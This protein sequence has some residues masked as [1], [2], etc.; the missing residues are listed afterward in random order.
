MMKY[1]ILLC[2]F[3]MHIS[4]V[5]D[6]GENPVLETINWRQLSKDQREFKK[7]Q[8]DVSDIDPLEQELKTLEYP[9]FLERLS[10]KTFSTNA[11]KYAVLYKH[12]RF[13]ALALNAGANAR[14]DLKKIAAYPLLTVAVRNNDKESVRLLLEYGALVNDPAFTTG[15]T[16]LHEAV[17]HN[18]VDIARLLLEYGADVDAKTVDGSTPLLIA[19]DVYNH[20][21]VKSPMIQLLLEYNAD[22][23]VV[24][25]RGKQ[26]LDFVKTRHVRALLLQ[27]GARHA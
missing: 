10:D 6:Y 14:V 18:H 11:L 7:F 17:L 2:L 3:S 25:A 4:G 27:K 22:V 24:T 1:I 19:I 15:M 20:N 23:N 8:K 9:E 13:A 26:P 21:T 5:T 16:A 12:P